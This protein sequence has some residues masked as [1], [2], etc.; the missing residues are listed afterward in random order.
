MR[1]TPKQQTLGLREIPQLGTEPKYEYTVRVGQLVSGS[2]PGNMSGNGS[3]F[4]RL[5]YD[6]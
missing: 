4:M 3:M 2:P 5:C 6:N 1:T